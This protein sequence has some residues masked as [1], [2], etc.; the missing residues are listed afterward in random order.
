ML[1]SK[2][3]SSVDD[4][5]VFLV[6]LVFFVLSKL[7]VLEVSLESAFLFEREEFDLAI[8]LWIPGVVICVFAASGVFFAASGVFFAASVAFFA[9][10]DA[11]TFAILSSLCCFCAAV[12][13]CVG[14]A[15]M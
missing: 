2:L 14:F 8:D 3:E 4:F 9:A 15:W 11:D 6:G 1:L 12:N 5:L 10:I 7:D 13:C